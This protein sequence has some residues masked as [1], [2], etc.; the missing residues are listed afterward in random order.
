MPSPLLPASEVRDL[1]DYNPDTG[2]LTWKTRSNLKPKAGSWNERNAGNVL[3]T[4]DSKGYIVI[5]IYKKKYRAHRIAWLIHYGEWP[6]LNL[7]HKNL[8]KTDNRIENLRE[9][10]VAQNGHNVGLTTRNSSG[11]RGI[12]WHKL[13]NKW[14]VSICVNRKGMYLGLYEKL[15]DAVVV[16]CEAE[17]LHYG[18]FAR[19]A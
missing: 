11:H 18:E 19:V 16:R 15:G 6:K 5:Q 1:I 13:A 8:D 17:R 4:R 3:S 2:V 12:Y 10:T 7:D 14:S 9:A